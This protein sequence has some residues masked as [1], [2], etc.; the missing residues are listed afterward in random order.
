M[1]RWPKPLALV[2]LLAA[3]ADQE[4]ILEGERLDIDAAGAGA[5]VATT[6]ERPHVFRLP[7]ATAEQDWTHRSGNARHVAVHPALGRSLELAWSAEIGQGNDRRHRITA[8]PVVAGGRVYALD[9]RALVS[10]HTTQG[11]PLWTRNLTPPTDKGDDASGGGLAVAGASLFVTSA[12][13]TLTALDAATGD[14]RW[15]QD[16]DAAAT[17]APT[18]ADG[19]VYVVTRNAIGWAIDAATGRILWQV[20]GAISPSGL[21]G[22]PA[23]AVS[24]QVVIFP[25]ASGQLVAAVPGPGTQVWA[26]SVAGRRQGRAFSRYSDLA[27]DPVVEGGIVYAGNHSGSAAALDTAT[28]LPVWQARVGA[29]GPVWAAGGS[30]F[31]VTDENQLVRLDAASG[32]TVWAVDLGFFTRERIKRRKGTFAHYGPVLA[33]G[34]LI[35]VSDDGL[36]REFDPV[37][38]ALVAQSELPGRAARNPVV[39]GG[40]LYVVTGRGQLHAF[41]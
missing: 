7:P 26:S 30:L 14:I 15:I 13:G 41:R 5:V 21:A 29:L 17:G 23:P 38:G 34:R 2:V 20:L 3:C 39:A 18:V 27:G 40:T 24:G 31:F 9:S 11:A 35:I 10:A 1:T 36:M 6:P 12:F 28:G 8:D 22:G 32:E 25:F 19:R 37:T 4:I 16:L 33:G